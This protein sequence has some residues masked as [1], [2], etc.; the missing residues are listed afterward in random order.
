MSADDDPTAELA[1]HLGGNLA[2]TARALHACASTTCASTIRSSR[3]KARRRGRARPQGAGQPGRLFPAAAPSARSSRHAETPLKWELLDARQAPWSPGRRRSSSAPTPPSGDSVHLVDFSR[4]KKPGKGYTLRVGNDGAT[5][6]TSAD[7]LYEKLKYDA[8]AYFYHNRSGI[9]IAMPYAGDAQWARPAGHLGDANDGDTSV[10][11]AP[12]SRLRL[13]ARRHRRLVRRRRPR[14]V[15]RQRRHLG[16]DAARTSTSAPSTSARSAAD[17]G[18]GKLNIPENENGVPDILDEARWEL[19]FLLKMQVPE[20][21]PLAG[22]GAPQD[23]RREVDRARHG[24][25]TRTRMERFLLRRRAP[26][27]R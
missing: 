8:L 20:G 26:R 3:R 27:R 24:A 6:S 15:R 12:G 11:C 13:L 21:K 5:R 19:E 16:L 25:R 2:G 22:H 18:D 14:Q 1:F 23:P 10:P 7:D 4:F 9:A 17:F